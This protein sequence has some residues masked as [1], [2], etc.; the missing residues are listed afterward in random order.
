M[1][2]A[3]NQQVFDVLNTINRSPDFSVYQRCEAF[4]PQLIIEGLGELALPLCDA[5]AKQLIKLCNKAPYGKGV[6][7]IVDEKVRK[8][9]ELDASNISVG[10]QLWQRFITTTLRGC[11]ER[12]DLQGQTLIAH[13]Y[14]L[15][16]YEEGSFFLTH[17]DSE[18]EDD[19]VATLVVALPSEHLGGELTITHRGRSVSI[20]FSEDAQ[21]YAFQ[22]VLFY[23]DCYHEVSPITSGYRLVFTYN[24]CLKGKRK[25]APFD[26]SMQQAALSEVIT[27]WNKNLKEEEDKKL[28]ISL[29]HQ[30][31]ADGFS[32]DAL[33]GIDR[34]RADSLLQSAQQAGCKAYLCLLEDYEMYQAW[35]EDELD[36][37]IENYSSINQLIDINGKPMNIDISRFDED[38]ILRSPEQ[39]GQAAIEAE[40]E[41]YTGNYGNTLSRWYRHAAVILWHQQYHLEVLAQNNT[42]VAISYLK[43][44]YVEKNNNF[45]QDLTVL[46]RMV[47]K[48][49]CRADDQSFTL[50]SLVLGQKDK[51]LAKLYSKYFL[52]TQDRLPSAKKI[53][54]LIGLC[55]WSYLEKTVV[56][57]K[58]TI[59]FR[60]F[61][62]LDKLKN[63]LVWDQ[64]PALKRLFYRAVEESSLDNSWRSDASKNFELI[65]SLCLEVPGKKSAEVFTKFLKQQSKRLSAENGVLPSLEK[66][67]ANKAKPENTAVFDAVVS[68]LDQ[69][70]QVYRQRIEQKPEAALIEAIPSIECH[71]EECKE[72]L[73]FMR[74]SEEEIE[75]RKL[76]AKCEHLESQIKLNKVQVT[77]HINKQRRPWRFI[78]RKLG[79]DQRAKIAS[80]KMAKGYIERLDKVC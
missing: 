28:I 20:D 2:K 63:S 12:L 79:A 58:A 30:Y 37:L 78:M 69:Q 11:E 76:K 16:L 40:Y 65:F 13:P 14:K 54:Q 55:G 60:L 72:I 73:R 8:V 47:D 46:L 33:K 48:G 26:F 38:S 21:R 18:K 68:W 45:Q 51:T 27:N 66:R 50:L 49:Q 61:E 80:Y 9:W 29:D 32:L 57:N 43:Q 35:D 19:M 34:S 71:C 23:A 10:N 6:Q 7:T 41:G 5:Q 24:I 56:L 62:M 75:L 59:R 70:F 77:H 39:D 17:Q 22:S 4:F 67:V 36:E 25:L 31:S 44:L 74:S 42:S 3:L 53:Q 1:P 52:L 64:H 15:L